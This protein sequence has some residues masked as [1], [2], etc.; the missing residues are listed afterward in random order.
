M[1]TKRQQKKQRA[2]LA[3]WESLRALLKTHG[4][5]CLTKTG[6]GGRRKW[7]A[8]IGPTSEWRTRTYFGRSPGDA[9]MAALF[10]EM[11]DG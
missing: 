2:A 4:Q 3:D 11:G 6:E 7:Q 9:L 8:A 5:V 10:G 1:L